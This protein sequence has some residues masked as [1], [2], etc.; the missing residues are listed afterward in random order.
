MPSTTHRVGRPPKYPW[1]AW[2]DGKHAY[3]V[4]QGVDFD[5]STRSFIQILTRTAKSRGMTAFWEYSRHVRLED[6]EEL[7]IWALPDPER[8]SGQ[9]E[10]DGE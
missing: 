7:T 6:A 10:D 5:C 4:E 8:E 2:L 3:T 9:E 1:D